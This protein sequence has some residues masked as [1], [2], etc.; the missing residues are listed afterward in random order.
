MSVVRTLCDRYKLN[1]GYVGVVSLQVMT[2][3]DLNYICHLN[4][5]RKKAVKKSFKKST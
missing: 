2:T 5:H 1:D 3:F 4:F